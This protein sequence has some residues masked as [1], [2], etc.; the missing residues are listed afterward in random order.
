[1]T[2]VLENK[3][4]FLKTNAGHIVHNEFTV[5]DCISWLDNTDCKATMLI[6]SNIDTMIIMQWQTKAKL[7]NLN[8]FNLNWSVFISAYRSRLLEELFEQY[9]CSKSIKVSLKK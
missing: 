5:W 6:K 4:N 3:C 9:D 1:M 7:K 2:S 8:K